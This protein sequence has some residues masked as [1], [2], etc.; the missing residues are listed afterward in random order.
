MNLVCDFPCTLQ[1]WQKADQDS[2]YWESCPFPQPIW[3][4]CK[5]AAWSEGKVASFMWRSKWKDVESKKKQK[6]AHTRE[7]EWNKDTQSDKM[8]Y[9][10]CSWPLQV[11]WERAVWSLHDSP[12]R[13]TLQSREKSKSGGTGASI[14]NSAGNRDFSLSHELEKKK[15]NRRKKSRL[16]TL[17]WC[18]A[19]HACV[20]LCLPL[21]CIYVGIQILLKCTTISLKY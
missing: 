11:I 19:V 10:V 12:A 16:S 4:E 2:E 14:P 1:E 7:R 8:R 21:F 5:K 9:T 15:R 6:Y 18:N 3:E 17:L 20:H 13:M